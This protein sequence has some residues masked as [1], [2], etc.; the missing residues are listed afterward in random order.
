MN[1]EDNIKDVIS[2]K[3]EDGTIEKLVGEQLE[4][5][6]VNA[7]DSLFRSY[8]DVTK[9]IENQVKSV[10]IP[11]LESYDY[12]KYI[13]KL[14]AVLTE[15]LNKAAIDNK[16]LLENF[17]GLMIEEER[18]SIKVTELFEMWKDYVR[19]NVKTDG[20]EVEYDDGVSYEYFNVSYEIEEDDD[21]SWSRFEHATLVFECE[22]DE[23]MNF[24][25]RLSHY[26]DSKDKGW[27]ISYKNSCNID[28]LRYLK[29]FDVLLMRL[30]RARVKLE[31]DKKY[32]NDDIKPDAE[33]EASFN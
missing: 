14:D 9:V 10:M 11:Y 13:L 30:D 23:D 28:T 2:K 29:D 20:L 33:P 22:H 1:L 4:K 7:L 12:S 19:K 8:G 16:K 27:D 3:L 25:I 24:E 6:V 5:G 18:K 15:V 31:I 17:K 21:R 32:D 26:K